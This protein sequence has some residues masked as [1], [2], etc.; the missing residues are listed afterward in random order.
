MERGD[1][2]AAEQAFRAGFEAAHD[3]AFLVR[4]GEAQ[5]KAGAP[6]EAVE[7]YRLYL[8][9]APDASDRADVEGRIARLAPPSSSPA[10]PQADEPVGA[11]GAGPNPAPTAV[12]VPAAHDAQMP[13]KPDEPGRPKKTSGLGIA[14][15]V[16][17]AATTA[18]LGVAAFYGASAEGKSGDVNQW[19]NY[20]DERGRPVEFTEVADRY[21]EAQRDGRRM[22]DNA[23]LALG[24]AAGTGA[25]ALILFLTDAF[26][27]P[28]DAGD[29]HVSVGPVTGGAVGVAGWSF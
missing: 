2:R 9:E 12:A 16:D 17:V 26:V 18:A 5:E 25:V 4:I 24:V 11:L 21:E 1:G 8:R 6:L 19:Q 14:A 10:K 20:R 13:A 7:S 29:A 28:R 27:G 15:W 22:N 23:H 3:P